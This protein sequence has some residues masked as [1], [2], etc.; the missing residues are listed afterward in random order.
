VENTRLPRF[1]AVLWAAVGAGVVVRL[2]LLF[3]KPLWADEIF[4]LN[5]ARKSVGEILAALRVDSGPPLHYLLAHALLSPSGP[6]P[7]PEDFLV[8]VLSVVAS[9]LH[10]PLFFRVTRLLGKPQAGLPAA[11]LFSVFPLTADYAAE[12]LAYALASLLVLYALDRALALREEPGAALAV[13]L[14]VT[15][16]AAVLTHYLALLPLLGL[17]VLFLDA[18]SDARR[19]L[20]LSATGTAL[21]LTGWA[22]VALKQPLASMA[23]SR[24]ASSHGAAR[25]FFANLVFGSPAPDK[26]LVVLLPLSLIG[27]ATLLFVSRK[28]PFAVIAGALATGLVFLVVAQALTGSV[29][30]PER[31]ALPFLPY[32]ALLLGAAPVTLSAPVGVAAAAWL[33]VR[34]PSLLTHS[35]GETL[36]SFLLPSVKAGKSVCAVAL[37][38][39]ELDYRFR[40]AGVFDR[41]V[42]FPSVVGSH[43]GWYQEEEMPAERLRAEAFAA[44]VPSPKRPSLFVLPRGSRATVALAEPLRRY[45]ARPVLSS[46]LVDVVELPGR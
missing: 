40:R 41:V 22:P 38:G 27:L 2:V 31:A 37:W 8:R 21:L 19:A 3:G 17:W 15:S 30:L 36:A 7:V 26:A 10:L 4:T 18:S 20:L 32:V 5:L 16:A 11:A 35:P 23:W 42:F 9:L 29:L 46:P 45:A 14:A 25:H 6:N 34:L 28:G 33:L 39:P 1:R 13:L 43:P 44:V 24:G 12:G